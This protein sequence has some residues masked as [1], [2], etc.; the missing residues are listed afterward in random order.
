MGQTIT[1]HATGKHL[2]PVKALAHIVHDILAHSGME[3]LLLCDTYLNDK[4]FPVESKH[5]VREVQDTCASLNLQ[6]RAIDP[7]LVGAHSL[8]AGGAMALKLHGYDDTT[9]MKMGRWTS[10]TFLQYIHNQIE[11]LSKD[12]SRKMSIELPSVNVAAI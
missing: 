10:L 7:D 2:C 3:D 11:H 5:M 8:R 9:I 1:Q 12:I 6:E 4:W